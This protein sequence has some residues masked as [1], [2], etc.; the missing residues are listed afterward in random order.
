MS[1]DL[2]LVFDTPTKVSTNGMLFIKE[3]FLR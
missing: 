2:I 1:W 3:V